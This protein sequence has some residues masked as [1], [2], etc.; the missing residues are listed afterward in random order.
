MMKIQLE[1]VFKASGVPKHTFVS[2][3]EYTELIVNLRTPGRG[4]V[5]EGPSGIGKTTAVETALDELTPS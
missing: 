4:L 5:V 1:E 2:P 3:K